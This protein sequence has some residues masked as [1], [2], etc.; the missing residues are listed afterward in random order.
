MGIC[1]IRPCADFPVCA[2]LQSSASLGPA[3][4][5]ACEQRDQV[6]AVLTSTP[7]RGPPAVEDLL[8]WSG[9]YS[10]NKHP[11]NLGETLLK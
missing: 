10:Y 1:E 11:H 2:P 7:A 8:L 3:A 4:A 9:L 6:A 5:P